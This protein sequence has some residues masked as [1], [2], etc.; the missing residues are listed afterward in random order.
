MQ[1]NNEQFFT[2]HQ[3][4]QPSKELLG[5]I[6]A[7][8]QNEKTLMRRRAILFA[9]V[10]VFSLV[11]FVPAFSA[12]RKEFTQS[13]LFEI[14]AL[15]F[16]DPTVIRIAWNDFMLSILESLPV[17]SIVVVLAT[18]FV[19]LSSLKLIVRDI[20]AILASPLASA[21]HHPHEYGHE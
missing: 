20:T 3:G 15:L 13:G 19:F 10:A 1:K 5:K 21:S 6:M 12:M 4:P 16:S 17:R 9:V 11:A 18:A 14:A 8:I 7:R 2:R